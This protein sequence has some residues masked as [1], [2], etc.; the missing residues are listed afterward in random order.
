MLSGVVEGTLVMCHPDHSSHIWPMWVMLL[1]Q[2]MLSTRMRLILLLAHLPHKAQYTS[3]REHWLSNLGTAGCSLASSAAFLG[4]TSQRWLTNTLMGKADSWSVLPK[5]SSP[6]RLLGNVQ[7]WRE[8]PK[9]TFWS[10]GVDFVGDVHSQHRE[11]NYLAIEHN[12]FGL[13]PYYPK[14]EKQFKVVMR[15][16]HQY[17]KLNT[18]VVTT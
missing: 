18:E 5:R 15:W 11:E 1:N 6:R 17:F 2:H 14:G 3:L 8:N 9:A 7:G 13:H 4:V 16:V 12:H 10:W